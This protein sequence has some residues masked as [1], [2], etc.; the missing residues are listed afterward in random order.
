MFLCRCLGQ[1]I[2]Y[3][4]PEEHGYHGHGRNRFYPRVWTVLFF[5]NIARSRAID[6]ETKSPRQPTLCLFACRHGEY[7]KNKNLGQDINSMKK[8]NTFVFPIFSIH[9][10]IFL[11]LGTALSSSLMFSI[12]SF[13]EPFLLLTNPE[14]TNLCKIGQPFHGKKG[15]FLCLCVD[16]T[17]H[18][19]ILL[20]IRQKNTNF[21][22]C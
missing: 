2:F 17:S 19:S 12:Y 9:Y 7:G 22:L 10:Y 21:F 5:S 18:V 11:D 6:L 20:S 14:R 13:H 16:V 15:C 3:V 1:E 4:L 8:F